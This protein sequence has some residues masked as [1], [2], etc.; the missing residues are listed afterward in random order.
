MPVVYAFRE[1]AY[2]ADNRRFPQV[3]QFRLAQERRRFAEAQRAGD[4][5][6]ARRVQ[7]RVRRAVPFAV[8]VAAGA[9]A[10][11]RGHIV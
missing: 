11:P 8:R 1:R 5:R 7:A 4:A 3:Y 9:M 10:A 2:V 6:G